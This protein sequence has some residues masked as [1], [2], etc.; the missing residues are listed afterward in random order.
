MEHFGN[1]VL[2]ASSPAV[3]NGMVNIG[4]DNGLAALD[5]K[6]GTGLW[7]YSTAPNDSSPAVANGVVYVGDR[8]GNIYALNATTGTLLWSYSVT[9]TLF[10]TFRLPP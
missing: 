2:S 7:F 1:A 4:S 6:T 9:P 10:P 3:A 8:D 5:A